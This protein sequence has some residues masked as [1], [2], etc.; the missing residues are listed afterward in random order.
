MV[1]VT[2][3]DNSGLILLLL[4]KEPISAETILSLCFHLF[5]PAR[6]LAISTA[7]LCHTMFRKQLQRAGK[8]KTFGKSE[9]A[10]RAYNSKERSPAEFDYSCLPLH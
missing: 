2:G 4:M 7:S 8:M 5:A 9:K 3:K 6:T 10:I 1:L